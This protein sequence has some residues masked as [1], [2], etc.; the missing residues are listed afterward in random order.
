MQANKN[1]DCS[2]GQ[3]PHPYSWRTWTRRQEVEEG[4]HDFQTK[5]VP[6]PLPSRA[7]RIAQDRHWT[8]E[9][10]GPGGGLIGDW[11]LVRGDW[12]LEAG[13]QEVFRFEARSR[14]PPARIPRTDL[15]PHRQ[16]ARVPR[17]VR[18]R[19]GVET[20]DASQVVRTR[21]PPDPRAPL[22]AVRRELFDG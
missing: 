14:G 8:L 2:P 16:K 21:L 17:G 9:I 3:Y 10:G 4:L 13:H 18:P 20:G 7:Y 19:E 6:L 22:G 15:I 11:R 1:G 12:R 5:S